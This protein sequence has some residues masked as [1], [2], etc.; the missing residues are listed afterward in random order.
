MSAQNLMIARR[1][2][3]GSRWRG[4][5]ST[6]LWMKSYTS[7][8]HS[9][10]NRPTGCVES[11][12]RAGIRFE[13]SD[14]CNRLIWLGLRCLPASSACSSACSRLCKSSL[15]SCTCASRMI[16]LSDT[17]CSNTTAKGSLTSGWRGCMW[18]WIAK[19]TPPSSTDFLMALK[20][21]QNRLSCTTETYRS[22]SLEN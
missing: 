13:A 9:E 18:P 4:A 12:I 11:F 19:S 1:G 22:R 10:R 14:L 8:P 17:S 6:R 15:D 16:E 7:C 20:G 3:M 5:S 21:W 2:G